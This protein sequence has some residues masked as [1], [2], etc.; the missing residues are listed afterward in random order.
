MP[1]FVWAMYGHQRDPGGWPTPVA[2]QS[3]SR[4]LAV[5]RI[6]GVGIFDPALQGDP[7]LFQPHVS[8]TTAT[9]PCTS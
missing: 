4:W 6:F 5:E 3:P 1:L 9:R 2:R 8:G 7:I